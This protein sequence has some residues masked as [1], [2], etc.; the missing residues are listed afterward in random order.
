MKLRLRVDQGILEDAA[1]VPGRPSGGRASIG[2]MRSRK[3]RRCRRL[4]R[5]STR[6]FAASALA[7]LRSSAMRRRARQSV[8]RRPGRLPMPTMRDGPQSMSLTPRGA[9]S[10]V[11]AR[12]NRSRAAQG[13]DA[14]HSETDGRC[15]FSGRASQI[16][17]HFRQAQLGPA[18]AGLALLPRQPLAQRGDEVVVS[19]LVETLAVGSP[20]GMRR[21]ALGIRGRDQPQ[22]AVEDARSGRR[23]RGAEPRSPRRR[24]APTPT[25]SGP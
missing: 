4:R 2:W 20:P 3:R 14:P 17:A 18:A 12:S 13:A 22:L 9:S 16:A 21:R 7:W 23:S 11:A 10:S 8:T 24:A 1:S 25:A 19:E 5:C 6:A 15:R